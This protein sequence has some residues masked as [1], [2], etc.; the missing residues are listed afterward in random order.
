MTLARSAVRRSQNTGACEA[1]A[2]QRT[3]VIA[4]RAAAENISH[5]RSYAAL[6]ANSFSRNACPRSTKPGRTERE[7]RRL[8]NQTQQA[9]WILRSKDGDKDFEEIAASKF[10][11]DE[12][13]AK[14][15]RPCAAIRL[16]LRARIEARACRN[17]FSMKDWRSVDIQ[18]R[19]KAFIKR[20]RIRGENCSVQTF[21][22]S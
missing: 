13:V 12:R 15:R 16:P 20:R 2:A 11:G 14:A 8:Q 6:S 7:P 5:R 17:S 3:R 21:V 22:A 19:Y 18:P 4:T 10:E 9:E 1:L